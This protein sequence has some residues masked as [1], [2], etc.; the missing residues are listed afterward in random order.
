MFF[1]RLSDWVEILHGFTKFNFKMNLEVSAFYLEK[2]KSFIPKKKYFF[3]RCQYQN[4]KALFTDSIFR[5]GFVLD[6]HRILKSD[7]MGKRSGQKVMTNW[8]HHLWVVP[9]VEYLVTSVFLEYLISLWSIH[10]VMHDVLNSRPFKRT[11]FHRKVFFSNV[12]I[13]HIGCSS[14]NKL[15]RGKNCWDPCP[16]I[17]ANYVFGFNRELLYFRE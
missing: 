9:F 1:Y 8:W 15:I 11:G 16:R 7:E 12:L 4:K 5:E 13:T 2:Q 6:H 14:K 10:N 17:F 3:G